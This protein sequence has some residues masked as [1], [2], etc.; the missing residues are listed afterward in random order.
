MRSTPTSKAMPTFSAAEIVGKTLIAKQ[1]VKVFNAPSY[2]PGAQQVATV[3][4]G[5]P[6]GVVF[7]W[8][9]GKAGQ[10]L[11]WQFNDGNRFFYVEHRSGAFDVSALKQQGALTPTEKAELQRKENQTLP[12]QIFEG[13]GKGARNVFFAGVALAAL[14]IVLSQTRKK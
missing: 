8:T 10:P 14:Y 11:N 13:L 9:G 5:E 6:V 1:N 4:A 2:T 7:S 12:E 3:R